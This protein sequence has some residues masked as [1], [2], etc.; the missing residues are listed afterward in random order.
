[1]CLEPGVK[2]RC[3][4]SEVISK[5]DVFACFEYCIGIL[6]LILLRNITCF[7]SSMTLWDLAQT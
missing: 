2:L 4:E 6:T 3:G 5:A 1:M 7:Q